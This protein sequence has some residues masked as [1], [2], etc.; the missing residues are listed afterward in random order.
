MYN[1]MGQTCIAFG[2]HAKGHQFIIVNVGAV[3]F[4]E[5]VLVNPVWAALGQQNGA[6]SVFVQPF[7]VDTA[8]QIIG[9]ALQDFLDGLAEGCI[10]DACFACGFGKPGSFERSG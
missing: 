4:G 8:T 9:L 1:G 5:Q 7:F 2:Q 6:V 3:F 10:A